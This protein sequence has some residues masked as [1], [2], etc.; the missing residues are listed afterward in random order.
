MM[1]RSAQTPL[2]QLWLAAYLA[3]GGVL[4]WLIFRR[5]AMQQ[6]MQ[7][8]YWVFDPTFTDILIKGWS[9]ILW[10]VIVVPELLVGRD[11]KTKN[12]DMV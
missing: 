3:V 4:T 1:R 2:L 9:V 10:P 5:E 12:G 11:Q 6:R 8:V 7:D